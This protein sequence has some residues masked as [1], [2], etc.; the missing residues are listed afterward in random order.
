[1]NDLLNL[2]KTLEQQSKELQRTTQQRLSNE[3]NEHTKSLQR[4][5][6]SSESTISA[7]IHALTQELRSQAST[8]RSTALST[9]LWLL[10][11]MIIVLVS[12]QGVLWYQGNQIAENLATIEQQN[13]TLKALQNQ[14]FGIATHTSKEGERFILLPN[15]W[16]ADLNWTVGKQSAIKL[17]KK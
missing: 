1:M 16:K 9:W 8:M 3:F 5:L 12:I 13:Q 17:E 4:E 11:T 15:G 6:K 10:L 14:T 2:T 7:D